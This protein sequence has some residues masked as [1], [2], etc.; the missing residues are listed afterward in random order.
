M[1]TREYQPIPDTLT[2]SRLSLGSR[3]FC[4]TGRAIITVTDRQLLVWP[5]RWVLSQCIYPN[6]MLARTSSQPL[7]LCFGW[8]EYPCLVNNRVNPRSLS[9]L[10]KD[11]TTPLPCGTEYDAG[12]FLRRTDSLWLV[13]YYPA[14]LCHNFKRCG[15]LPVK[16]S[17][18]PELASRRLLSE[19]LDFVF[20]MLRDTRITLL[21]QL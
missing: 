9:D 14:L 20:K 10:V 1:K 21:L 17:R 15:R 7:G 4:R 6:A 11:C 18:A 3:L 2:Q 5:V 19:Y 13:A 12:G 8:A 16:C